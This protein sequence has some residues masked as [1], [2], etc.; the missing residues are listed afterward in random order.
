MFIFEVQ[1]VFSFI[2]L[3][4]FLLTNSLQVDK[5]I[6]KMNE[7]SIKD[8]PYIVSNKQTNIRKFFL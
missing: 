5:F 7:D 1:E 8:F 4:Y 6:W 3:V 2:F